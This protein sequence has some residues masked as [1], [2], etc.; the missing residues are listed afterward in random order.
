MTFV[1]RTLPPRCSCS[2][3]YRPS[4]AG[5][6][7]SRKVVLCIAVSLLCSEV[8]NRL[9]STLPFS[10][11]P[12]RTASHRSVPP[13]YYQCSRGG[14]GGGGSRVRTVL[15]QTKSQSIYLSYNESSDQVRVS[16]SHPSVAP[17]FGRWFPR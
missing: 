5:V 9:A 7:H 17:C 4:F 11:R 12:H 10:H 3:I 8:Y 6:A 2:V 14:R 1:G 16:P 15:S 13:R